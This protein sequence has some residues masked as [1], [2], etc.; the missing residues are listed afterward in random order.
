MIELDNISVWG[1][2]IIFLIIFVFV[3]SLFKK[4]GKEGFIQSETFTVKSGLDVYDGMYSDIYDHLVLNT[5]KNDYEIGSIVNATNISHKSV[6]LDIGSGTGHHVGNLSSKGYNV[7]GIDSSTAMVKKAK[8]NYPSNTFYNKNALD[9]TS[10]NPNSFTHVLCMYFTIYEI[11]NKQVF[12][13]NV[14]NW[15]TPGGYC[16]VHLV[17]RNKFDPIL[18]PGNPILFGSLQKHSEKRITTTKIKFTDFSYSADFKMPNSELDE[19][20]VFEEK[21]QNDDNG[22]TRKNEHHLYMPKVNQIKKMAESQGFLSHGKI[23]LQKCQYDY[24][25]LYI[26]M[27]PREN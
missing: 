9:S 3:I 15:L 22:K 20:C 19:K 11:Q 25:Y 17:N 24:Q 6:I 5:V 1:Y 27:K 26:F 10:F 7:V 8:E 18:P 2:L 13:K 16:V 12:F 14:F 21:L 23:D 4:S